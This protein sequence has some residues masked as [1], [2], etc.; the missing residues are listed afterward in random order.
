M[1]QVNTVFVWSP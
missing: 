1:F